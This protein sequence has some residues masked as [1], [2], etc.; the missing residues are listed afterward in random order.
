MLFVYGPDGAAHMWT[1]ILLQPWWSRALVW[2]FL[3][4]VLFPIL[5]LLLAG[6]A[7]PHPWRAVVVTAAVAVFVGV[8][9]AATTHRSHQAYANVLNELESPHRSAAI[10]ASRTGPVPTDAGVRDTAIRLGELHL[11]AAQRGKR[12]W[13]IVA[14]FFGLALTSETLWGDPFPPRQ[15]LFYL[16]VVAL[17]LCAMGWAW[18][19]SRR[20]QHR[21]EMLRS[22]DFHN[23]AIGGAG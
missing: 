19:S 11:R 23:A 17:A 9:A 14:C 13:L 6:Q 1:R 2:A 10:D 12:I 16:I 18:Y 4:A 3:A 5:G 21:L 7:N 22:A 15:K 8:V 20:V